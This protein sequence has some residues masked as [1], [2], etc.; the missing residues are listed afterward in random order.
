MKS[1][2]V[3]AG[4]GGLPMFMPAILLSHFLCHFGQCDH[5]MPCQL[6]L[7][8]NNL[9]LLAG[10]IQRAWCNSLLS[11]CFDHLGGGPRALTKERLQPICC[12]F[13]CVALA[14]IGCEGLI[15]S[16]A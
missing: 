3:H 13:Y 15:C 4:H 16:D 7:P 10:A 6:A 2:V 5:P 1:W 11:R 14:I 8:R 9:Q 12:I